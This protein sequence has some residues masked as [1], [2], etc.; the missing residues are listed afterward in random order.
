MIRACP[1]IRSMRIELDG[2]QDKTTPPWGMG[3]ISG[4][5][6]FLWAVK[7]FYFCLFLGNS[8]LYFCVHKSRFA[9]L[10]W[11]WSQL[12]KMNFEGNWLPHL[13]NCAWVQA[14]FKPLE[15]PQLLL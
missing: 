14:H 9:K 6:T 13:K 5:P 11:G 2:K 1:H 8:K 10:A 12:P 7:I 15:S 4:K 3:G